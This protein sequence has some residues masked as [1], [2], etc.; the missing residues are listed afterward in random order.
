MSLHRDPERDHQARRAVIVRRFVAGAHVGE[1][2]AEQW[3]ADWERRAS[4]LGIRRESPA[5]WN[6]GLRWIAGRRDQLQEAGRL[7]DAS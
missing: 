4:D 7:R 2:D 6:A 3:V 1:A 5:Y